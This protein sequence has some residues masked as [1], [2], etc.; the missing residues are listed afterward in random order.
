VVFFSVTDEEL[1][2]YRIIHGRRDIDAE[3][4]R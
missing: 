2:V 1:I 3:L 4:K